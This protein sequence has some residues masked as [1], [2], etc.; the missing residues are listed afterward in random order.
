MSDESYKRTEELDLEMDP[1]YFFKQIIE[2]I[3]KYFK[4]N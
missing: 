3:K 2:W 4:K 1:N